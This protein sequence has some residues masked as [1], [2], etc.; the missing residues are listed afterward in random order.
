MKTLHALSKLILVEQATAS[1]LN[2]VMEII[3]DAG[4]WLCSKGIT[5]QWPSKRP[6]E[7]WVATEEAIQNGQVYVARIQPSGCIVG[8]L[9]FEWTDP[10]T[11]PEDPDSAAY[12]RSIAIRNNARGHRIGETL[13]KWAEE[14]ARK[15]GKRYLRLHC[16]AENT[17]LCKYY[18]QMGFVFCGQVQ[19]PRWVGALYQLEIGNSSCL[20]NS[21]TE[22]GQQ[23]DF[24]GQRRGS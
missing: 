12:V 23:N 20:Q 16:C 13:L 4:A 2:V 7:S 17:R 6:K 19:L 8:T 3:E 5:Y 18:E 10:H 24:V 14:H 1:D 21:I 15:N 11:W 22:R 9:R